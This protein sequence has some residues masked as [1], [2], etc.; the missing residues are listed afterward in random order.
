MLH[1]V[2]ILDSAIDLTS[3][4]AA[5]EGGA[6]TAAA[7]CALVESAMRAR[8]VERLANICLQPARQLGCNAVPSKHF[9]APARCLCAGVRT[10]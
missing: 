5:G 9:T 4:P 2:R 3:R 10:K 1:W 7:A 8:R 6:A